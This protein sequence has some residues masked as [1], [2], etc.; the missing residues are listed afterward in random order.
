MAPYHKIERQHLE[1]AG[2]IACCGAHKV[3][4][5]CRLWHTTTDSVSGSY[6]HT[7]VEIIIAVVELSGEKTNYQWLNPITAD[8][9][10]QSKGPT[11]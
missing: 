8:V 1:S 3:P 7:F 9:F 4:P 11:L 2:Y 6:I 5:S 10:R